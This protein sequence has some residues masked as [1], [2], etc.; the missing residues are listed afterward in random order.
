MN[1]D[2]DLQAAHS[3]LCKIIDNG[4]LFGAIAKLYLEQGET[5]HA[6]ILECYDQVHTPGALSF[7]GIELADELLDYKLRFGGGIDLEKERI[8]VKRYGQLLNA[9]QS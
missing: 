4:G 1:N 5:E 2:M 9:T 6:Y 3:L 8:N 7:W